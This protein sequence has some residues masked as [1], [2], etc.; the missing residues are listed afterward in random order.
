M[1]LVSYEQ[2]LQNLKDKEYSPLYFLFGEE[3]VFIE[4]LVSKFLSEVLQ[5]HEKD[6][7]SEVHD[8]DNIDGDEILVKINA[9]PLMSNRRLI[10]IKNCDKVSNLEILSDYFKRPIDTSILVLTSKNVD[11]RK[12]HFAILKENATSVKCEY[13]K[14]QD[15]TNHIDRYV[16]ERG[17]KITSRGIDLL[18]S[19]VGNSLLEIHNA[20]DKVILLK[21]KVEA[22][23]EKDISAIVG[24]S[25]EIKIFELTNYVGNGELNKTLTLLEQILRQ[26]EVPIYIVVMLTRHFTI[27]WKMSVAKSNNLSLQSIAKEYHIHPYYISQYESHLKKY[28]TNEIE[29]IILHLTE[30]DKKLKSSSLD[31]TLV[32]ELLMK[33][34]ISKLPVEENE[35]FCNV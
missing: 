25:R 5:P 18:V 13:L 9:F 10:I 26:G 15:L 19:Y 6:F 27:L 16:K 35:E 23:E 21:D 32:V 22:I 1:A 34:I 28:S 7:N 14:N 11:L 30:A 17:K 8:G 4:N 3:E 31:K 2:L 29:N 12:I 24:A 33:N 20:L